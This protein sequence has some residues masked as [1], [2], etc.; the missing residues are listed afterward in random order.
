MGTQIG[1]LFSSSR[2][3]ITIDALSGNKI[4]FDAYN[5]IYAFLARIRDKSTGGGY[6]TDSN[7]NVTSHLIGLFPRLT[8]FLIHDVKPIFIFDGK[9]PDFKISEIITRKERKKEAEVKRE[10]A[11]AAG[12]MDEASKYAQATS[13]ITPEILEDTKILL[14]NL[15]IPIVQAPSEAEAQGAILTNQGIINAMASQDYD[16]FLFGCSTVIRNLGVSQ[17]RKL[18]NQQRFIEVETERIQLNQL[19][20]ELK[21]KDREQ[22]ILVGLLIGTDYNPKGIKGIGPK[23]AL[24][25]VQKY[26]NF[27]SL[28][29]HLDAT[30]DLEKIFPYPP[31]VL[32]K[33][34]LSPEV[35]ENVKISYSDPKPK[36]VQK[37]LVE[38]RGFTP[39]RIQRQI[40]ALQRITSQS[41]LDTF[42]GS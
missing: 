39:E 4:G 40:K 42:F 27:D 22:L 29:T 20:N 6:F 15:G 19:L 37:F 10:L 8:H 26:P 17:R 35:D 31:D 18:P 32:L 2:Q 3:T 7:G 23:T 28:F 21:L 5:T 9:P 16:S 33:Y 12:D 30:Y 36:K 25:L 24:K 34:F 13:R 14:R 11:I 38:E 41:T 1:K